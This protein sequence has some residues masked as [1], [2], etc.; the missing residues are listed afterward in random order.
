MFKAGLTKN[1]TDNLDC[2][3]ITNEIERAIVTGKAISESI[4]VPLLLCLVN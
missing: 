4:A 3:L 1:G 2:M